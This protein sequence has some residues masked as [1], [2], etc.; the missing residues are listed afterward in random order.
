MG[1]PNCGYFYSGHMRVYQYNS[2]SGQW[3][4]MGRDLH[5]EVED[6]NAGTSV[7][8]S[9]DGSRVAWELHLVTALPSTRTGYF[10]QVC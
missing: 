4:I 6:D 2:D 9:G 5:G 1:A 8:I 7:T 3:S 10:Q